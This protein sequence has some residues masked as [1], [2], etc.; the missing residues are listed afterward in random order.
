MLHLIFA[1]MDFVFLCFSFADLSR[2]DK[3]KQCSCHLH[4][5]GVG[6]LL[7]LFFIFQQ[8]LWT[9]IKICIASTLC[10]CSLIYRLKARAIPSNG[11]PRHWIDISCL[12]KSDSTEQ[13]EEVELEFIMSFITGSYSDI[14]AWIFILKSV[15]LGWY[16]LGDTFFFHHFGHLYEWRFFF[17]LCCYPVK[18]TEKSGKEPD[19]WVWWQKCKEISE[20][21]ECFFHCT[22]MV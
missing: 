8:Y 14:Y 11:E 20:K 6:F 12:P 16:P 15:K 1:Y 5:C 9:I 2:W 18:E 19:Y 13:S 7:F 17:C 10:F 3:F 21:K 22:H 4:A